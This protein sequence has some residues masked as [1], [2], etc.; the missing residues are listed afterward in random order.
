MKIL[1]DENNVIR[2]WQTVGGGWGDTGFETVEVEIIPDEV[3]AECGKF[4]YVDGMF[5]ENPDYTEPERVL[6]ETEIL[7]LAVAELAESIAGGE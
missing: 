7:A 3:K 6:S 1:I 2:E 5:E 4:R